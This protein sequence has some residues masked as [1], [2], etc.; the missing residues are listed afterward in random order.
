MPQLQE[1]P[2]QTM[3]EVHQTTGKNGTSIIFTRACSAKA[4]LVMPL[5]VGMHFLLFAFQICAIVHLLEKNA[6]EQVR[7]VGYTFLKSQHNHSYFLHC[8]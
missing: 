6:R 4:S 7:E 3:A 5:T 8:K 1:V 2:L